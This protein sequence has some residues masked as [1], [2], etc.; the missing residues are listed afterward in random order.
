[1]RERNAQ[2]LN[3][4]LSYVAGAMT[5]LRGSNATRYD[6]MTI[7]GF[8]PTMFL[9]GMRLLGGYYASPQIDFHRLSRVDIVKG[10]AVLYGNAA[11][12]AV[13]NEVSKLPSARRETIVDFSAGNY[14]LERGYLDTTGSFDKT[15]HFLYRLIGGG[16]AQHGYLR[17]TRNLRYYVSPEMMWTPDANTSVTFV[18]SY[19]RDPK[20]GSYGDVEPYGSVL[21][22]PNGR[23]ARNF[24]DGDPSF[25]RFDR[26]QGSVSTLIKHRFSDFLTFRSNFRYQRLTL[27]F[28]D[29]YDRGLQSDQRTISRGLGGSDENMGAVTLD[30]SFVSKFKTG[31]FHHTLL[32]GQDYWE[33]SGW[34]RYGWHTVDGAGQAIP[35]Q[36]IFSPVYGGN[37]YTDFVSDLPRTKINQQQIGVYGQDQIEIGNLNLIGSI[38]Q[39]YYNAKTGTISDTSLTKQNKITWRAAALY[40]FDFGLSPY[41]SYST[42]FEPQTGVDVYGHSY[43]PI[44][45]RQYE[46]GLKYQPKGTGLLLTGSVFDIARNNALVTDPENPNNSIQIGESRTKGVELEGRAEI[47]PGLQ[48]LVAITYLDSVYARGNSAKTSVLNGNLAS[49][50]TGKHALGVPSWMSSTFLSYDFR[51]A[52]FVRGA[53]HGLMVGGGFRYTGP[54]DGVT[55]TIINGQTANLRFRVPAYTLGEITAR[56]DF[57]V[58]SNRMH[59]LTIQMNIDNIAGT[60]YVSSC[61]VTSWCWYGAPRTVVG[62]LHYQW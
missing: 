15:G 45:G 12:G 39:D 35:S 17:L 1:M 19:Q 33:N 9:D 22:N 16:E 62:S 41:F 13:V 30:N 8:T 31:I 58:L 55:T 3:Q 52:R 20:N 24:Y 57:S 59:G 2:S 47:Y 54:T 42:S 4:A 36:D 34:Y 43:K 37:H 50:V 25:E 27:S 38:R 18:G 40:H 10:P 26:Q 7:R 32:A 29:L 21:H 5:N 53:F 6:Q 61:S 48:F 51:D 23:I 49:G 60:K 56:Y 44:A 28:R 11:P 46:A 14:A